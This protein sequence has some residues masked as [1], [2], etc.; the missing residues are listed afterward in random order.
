LEATVFTKRL[1]FGV[2]RALA[3]EVMDIPES[4]H[5]P[6]EELFSTNNIA[7][8]Q[9]SRQSPFTVPKRKP[10]PT[11]PA[12]IGEP[13]PTSGIPVEAEKAPAVVSI[14]KSRWARISAK[15]P[16][17]NNKLKQRIFLG[18][19]VVVIVLVVL[20]M[21]LAVGLTVGRR[22]SSNNN[23][24]LPTS[25]GGPYKGDLTYYEPALG[26]CGLY[27]TSSDSIC[28]VSHII[29]DAV[30]KGSNPNANPL[31]G[32]KLRLRRA[33]KSVDVTVVDRCVGCEATDI[34]TTTSVFSQLANI[35]EG[36]VLVEWAWLDKPPSGVD[37]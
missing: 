24:P 34:D 19:V 13:T 31:C 21:P 22:G 15:L 3:S 16:F 8:T 1:L 12:I 9:Q 2:Y 14:P 7:Q 27:D 20:V 4:S 37:G 36:R 10:V 23:L 5:P 30:S 33:D 11:T 35:D 28:A 26:A 17:A 18:V 25:N 32:L 29:Y 6:S